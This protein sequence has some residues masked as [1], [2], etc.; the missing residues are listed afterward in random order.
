MSQ[1]GRENLV[2]LRGPHADADRLGRAEAVE[3]ADDD[4]LPQ[5]PLE[6]L[7]PAA[8]V[9]EEEVPA[10]RLGRLEAVAA[11]DLGQPLAPAAVQLPPPRDLLRVVEARERR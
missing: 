3:R 6:Q 10:C 1:G 9:G 11:Q 8:D 7:A 5:Q 2:L 4:P